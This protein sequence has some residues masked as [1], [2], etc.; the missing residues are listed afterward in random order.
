MAS[1][2]RKK[3]LLEQW[4]AYG[5]FFIGFDARK[6]AVRRQVFLYSC[7]YT[8]NDIRKWIL[9]KE[10]MDE[11]KGLVDDKEKRNGAY[12]LLYV[13]S[14]KYKNKHFKSEKEIR[15]IATS[16]HNWSYQNTPEMY[17]DDLPIHFRRH[18][19]YGFLVPYVKF[20]IE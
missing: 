15:L 3:D 13:A 14:M 5:N 4:R 11:W 20:F 9:K 10:K 18:P 12:N 16:H 1:F 17:E 6:L 8:E 2:S 19:V 7:L